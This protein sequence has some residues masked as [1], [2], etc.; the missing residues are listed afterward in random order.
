M[1]MLVGNYGWHHCHRCGTIYTVTPAGDNSCPSCNRNEE[2][3][4]IDKSRNKKLDEALE[5][6]RKK[7]C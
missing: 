4:E 7:P 1:D 5:K 3:I 2:Q 6:I